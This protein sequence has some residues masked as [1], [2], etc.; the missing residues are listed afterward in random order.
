MTLKEDKENKLKDRT[1]PNFHEQLVRLVE[2][3]AKKV[4]GIR[5]GS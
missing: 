5:I 1:E 3:I 2:K 4:K